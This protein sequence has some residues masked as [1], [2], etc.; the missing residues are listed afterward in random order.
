MKD[1]RMD[2]RSDRE[3]VEG[4][5]QGVIERRW[6]DGCKEEVRMEDRVM[7]LK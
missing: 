7:E 6:K 1:G 4:W 5:M 3:R 2:A